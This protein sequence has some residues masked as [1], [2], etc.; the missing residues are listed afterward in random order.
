M[1]TKSTLTTHHGVNAHIRH[2]TD[3]ERQVF[4]SR[5]T[6]TLSTENYGREHPSYAPVSRRSTCGPTLTNKIAESGAARMITREATR[7]T[8]SACFLL[9]KASK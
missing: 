3:I 9:L 7:A 6:V 2:E 1:T 8:F 5:L 4:T